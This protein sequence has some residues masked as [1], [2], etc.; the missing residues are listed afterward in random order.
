MRSKD[1]KFF[2]AKEIDESI[3]K[4]I[5]GLSFRENPVIQ[6]SD[7]SFIPILHCGFDRKVH[8]RL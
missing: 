2:A 6:V 4:R 5:D 3:F 8:Y 1:N 7:L